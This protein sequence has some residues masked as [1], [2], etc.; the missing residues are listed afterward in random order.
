MT[1]YLQIPDLSK[2]DLDCLV[3]DCVFNDVDMF[4]TSLYDKDVKLI[5]ISSLQEFHFGIYKHKQKNLRIAFGEWNHPLTDPSEWNGYINN[6]VWTSSNKFT[7]EF[8]Q[9]FADNWIFEGR[10]SYNTYMNELDQFMSK[11]SPQAHVCIFLGS[12]IAY[13]GE[14]TDAWVDRHIIHKEANERLRAYAQKN[15]RIHLIDYTELITS[16]K[17]YTDSIDHMQR[18]IHYQAAEKANEVIR[19]VIGQGIKMSGKFKI[20]MNRC[21]DIV[22]DIH[23]AYINYR[24][25]RQK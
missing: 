1:N 4:K 18:H 12:E 22:T 21:R 5:F 10:K 19:N 16:D 9:W 15:P 25:N 24:K 23:V 17:D 11:I 6:L 3:N 20:I 13:N 14:T 8:L 2:D 7:K